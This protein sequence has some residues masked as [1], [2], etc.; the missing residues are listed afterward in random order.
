MKKIVFLRTYK[1]SLYLKPTKEENEL[2][3]E[4]DRNES[5]RI[6]LQLLASNQGQ[7]EVHIDSKF[8]NLTQKVKQGFLNL[9][10]P[11]LSVERR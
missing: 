3:D 9:L 4:E 2:Y 5:V 6:F 8:H 7:G 11:D 1:V 10:C